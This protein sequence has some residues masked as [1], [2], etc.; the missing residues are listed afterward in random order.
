MFSYDDY[1]KLI[2]Q[3]AKMKCNYMQFW[4]FSYEPWLKYS[5]K[6][7]TAMLGFSRRANP[8]RLACCSRKKLRCSLQPDFRGF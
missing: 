3:M 6:G 2:D 8:R 7:E 1:A 5:Y 4:W